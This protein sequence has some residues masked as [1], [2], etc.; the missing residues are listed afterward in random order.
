METIELAPFK[1]VIDGLK[2]TGG[3]AFNLCYQCGTCETACPW[4]RVR[5]FF[6]RT[7]MHQS[8]L[9]VVD[10][11][12]E[13][14]WLCATCGACVQRCPRGVE[15]GEQRPAQ[16]LAGLLKQRVG[17][18]QPMEL[19]WIGLARQGPEPRAGPA[20][21]D[22]W[23]DLSHRLSSHWLAPRE[24]SLARRLRRPKAIFPM[25]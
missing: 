13:D 15:I 5:D 12:S 22:K 8:Q 3:E 14:L 11:G 21:Q 1:D 25:R 24:P 7:M 23:Q 19:L 10:F 20:A 2:E 18:R 16:S 4:N 17:A 9:G 6:I